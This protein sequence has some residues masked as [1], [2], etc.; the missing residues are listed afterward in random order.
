MSTV[1]MPAQRL[2][3]YTA[4]AANRRRSVLLVGLFI[5]VVGALGYVLGEL[6]AQ[7]WGLLFLLLA[8]L[9]ATAS[10]AGSYFAG[11]RIVLGLSRAREVSDSEQPV[12]HHV[13]SA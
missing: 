7:G 4:I 5:V 3:V 2:N 11:D 8:A 10:A 12:L 9:I 13:A 6:Y 1:Q